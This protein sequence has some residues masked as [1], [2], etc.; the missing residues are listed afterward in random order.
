M[1][2]VTIPVFDAQLTFKS[3]PNW[4]KAKDTFLGESELKQI[5]LTASN[6]FKGN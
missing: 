2:K 6:D 1:W 4:V 5:F 3:L